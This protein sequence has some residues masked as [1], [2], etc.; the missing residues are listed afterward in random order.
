M[1]KNFDDILAKAATEMGVYLNNEQLSRFT[2]YYSELLA[3]NRKMNLVSVKSSLDIPIKHFIDSLTPLPYLL[4]SSGRL[5]D[6]GTGAGFPG[7]P[8]KIAMPSLTVFLLESS[9][10]KTSFLKHIIRTLGL[11]NA[12]VIHNRLEYVMADGAYR[13]AFDIMISRA[14]FKLPVLLRIGAFFLAGNGIA[15]AMKGEQASEEMKEAVSLCDT[16]G[17]C[18][19]SCHDIRLP[20]IHDSRKIILFKKV[21]DTL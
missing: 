4:N 11:D 2:R 14:T 10:K 16:L 9:R 1:E 21:P 19:L 5:L 17:F 3:W 8:M 6:I 15:V 18:C 20:I 7:L 12:T 13:N